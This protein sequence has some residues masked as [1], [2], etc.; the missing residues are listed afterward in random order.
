MISAAMKEPERLE[1]MAAAAKQ[2]GRPDAANALADL[3]ICVAERR[4][5]SEYKGVRA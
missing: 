1:K 2:A 4:P 5:I 3:V